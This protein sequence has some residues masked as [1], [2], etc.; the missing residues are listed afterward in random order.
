MSQQG[1]KAEGKGKSL[2]SCEQM[3]RLHLEEKVILLHR[4]K[5]N[6]D[7]AV[8]EVVEEAFSAP[9]RKIWADTAPTSSGDPIA[10][11]IEVLWKASPHLFDFTIHEVEGGVQVYINRCLFHDVAKKLGAT[12]WGTKLFCSDYRDTVDTF[13]PSIAFR[14]TKTLMQG[15]AHCDFYFYLKDR[16]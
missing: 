7:P 11:L 8:V 2:V 12:A 13:N 16:R 9:L 14:C 15:D 10:D 1:Q 3:R 5:D 4:L 6:T